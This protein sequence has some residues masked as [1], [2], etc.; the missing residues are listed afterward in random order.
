MKTPLA[1][2]LIV[3]GLALG[4]GGGFAIN[5]MMNKPVVE[6]YEQQVATLQASLD[7]IGAV[8][9]TYTLK[10]TTKPGDLITEDMLEVQSV[11]LTLVP[12][13][14][15]KSSEEI[16][17]MYSKVSI[18]PGTA[19][20]TDLIMQDDIKNEKNLYNTVREY[21]VVVN[22][23]PI[24]LTIG[25]YVDMRIIMPYGEEYIVLSHMR[26]D[27]M[28]DGVVKFKMTE[29]QI[30]LYQS[31]LVD[32]YLNSEQGVALYFTKYIE[33]G[34]QKPANITYKVNDEIMQAMKKN[35][36]LYA[37]AWAS[38]YDATVRSEIESDLVL[39]E[40]EIKREEDNIESPGSKDEDNT[41]TISGGRQNWMS[42]VQSGGSDYVDDSESTESNGEEEEG[43]DIAW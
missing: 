23:W 2:G 30:S 31:A 3:A 17:G 32:Y 34:V 16:L 33:P 19:L 27:G 8:T 14:A 20:T 35:S 6:T 13:N 22:M 25:D 18:T 42:T 10:V 28:S 4:G 9:T 36:N 26:V 5:Y 39:T 7:A 24:G 38:V 1:V 41:G 12:A 11:P 37:T 15:I 43:G 21:D 40:T 29:A